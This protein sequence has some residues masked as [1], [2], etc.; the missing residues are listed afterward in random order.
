MV[1]K[2]LMYLKYS[3]GT[4]YTI[5]IPNGM[6][7]EKVE[8]KGFGN[9]V[10]SALES[11]NGKSCAGMTGNSFP[12]HSSGGTP[13]TFTVTP[14]E[15]VSKNI[16]LKVSGAEGILAIRLY[17]VKNA[18]TQAGGEYTI[19]KATNTGT[20]TSATWNFNNTSS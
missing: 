15:P 17:P 12:I 9:K 8:F 10:I 1:L 14:D 6:A 11:V 5:T 3:K 13:A 19:S 16:T 20:N 7:I 4:E 18:V 2:L